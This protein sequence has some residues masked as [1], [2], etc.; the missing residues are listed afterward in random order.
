MRPIAPKFPDHP[1]IEERPIA[2]EQLEYKTIIGARVYFD[3]GSV[4][5]F[6]RWTFTP[7]ERERIAN[8]EDVYISFPKYMAPHSVELRPEWAK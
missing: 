4:Q 7:E 6:A 8:G 1:Q 3:D 5:V 2:E